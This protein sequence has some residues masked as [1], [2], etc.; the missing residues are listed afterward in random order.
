MCYRG[1]NV[2]NLDNLLGVI[3]TYGGQKIALLKLRMSK[4]CPFQR[5]RRITGYLVGD[6][7]RWNTAKKA[8]ERDR[9]KHR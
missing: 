2:C 1:S 7:S 5:I 4:E 6:I 9:V 8:E 3:Y